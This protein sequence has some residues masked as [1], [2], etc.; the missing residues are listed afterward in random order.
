MIGGPLLEIQNKTDHHPGIVTVFQTGRHPGIVTVSQTGRHPGIVTVSQT[1]R[2]PG[3]V[4]V[5][6]TDLHP[7][8][9]I[10]FQTDRLHIVDTLYLAD[11]HRG[12]HRLD[13]QITVSGHLHET[14]QVFGHLRDTQTISAATD[15]LQGIQK[16]S[17]T[18]HL[19]DTVHKMVADLHYYLLTLLLESGTPIHDLF[20][21]G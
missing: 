1:D 17:A 18:D 7:G 2:H 21:N 10:V 4:T 5:S 11:R 13:I 12:F 8:I 15:H 20:I 6:Q 14:V 16:C 19:L 3:I 9:V